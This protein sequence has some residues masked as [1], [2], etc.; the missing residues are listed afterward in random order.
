ATT[1]LGRMVQSAQINEREWSQVGRTMLG[2][3]TAMAGMGVATL[4]TG[5]EY[6]SLRQTATQALTAVTGST[7]MAAA[8]MRRLDEFGRSSFLMRDVLIRAQQQMTG[9]GIETNKVIPY[10]S[11]LQ[12]AVAAT[13]G[14]SQDFEELARVMGQIQSQGK[15][16]ARELMQFGIR[17]VDAA[18]LIG[19]SMGKTAGQI[20][21]EITAGTL[22]AGVALDAL[23][24]GMGERFAGASDLVRETFQGAM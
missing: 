6:N 12:D 3:G 7:E 17:G 15:I 2:V 1:T 10:M 13:G 23:A 16:T 4:K 18:Q 24:D 9:F 20:R 19:D 5:I 14:S 21:D 8:Q 22:D 11:A